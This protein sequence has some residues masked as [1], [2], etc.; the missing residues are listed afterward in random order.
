MF[1]DGRGGAEQAGL[2]FPSGKPERNYAESVRLFGLAARQGNKR[3]QHDLGVM[4]GLG[5]GVSQ[6]HIRAHMWFNIA[7]INGD[8][9]SAKG[10]ALAAQQMTPQQIAEA[11]RMARECMNSNF[12]NCD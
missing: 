3:A 1:K 12:K 11:Q 8:A 5:Q 7:A 6:D 2:V 9:N 4:Y 10:R